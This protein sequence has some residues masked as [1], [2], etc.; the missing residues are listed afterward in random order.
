MLC[1]WAI[2]ILTSDS[3]MSSLLQL[4]KENLLWWCQSMVKSR[5][6][7]I[8]VFIWCWLFIVRFYYFANCIARFFFF[9]FV[10]EK[11]SPWM[12]MHLTLRT[13]I[14]YLNIRDGQ[15]GRYLIGIVTHCQYIIFL[16][17]E[18]RELLSP[19]IL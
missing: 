9:I 17:K 5:A 19:V 4:E 8:H 6:S 13:L 14:P 16:L 11:F 2:V 10:A 12:S 3:R 7:L 18:W 15:Q 1:L